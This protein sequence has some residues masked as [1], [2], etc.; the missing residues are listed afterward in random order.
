MRVAITSLFLISLVVVNAAEPIF[1][2]EQNP[3]SKRYSILEED[4]RVAW[5]YLTV[6]GESRPE[7]DALAYSVIEPVERTDW[8]EVKE[9]RSPALS[10]EY[11]S[12]HAVL[13]DRKVSDFSFRWADAGASVALLFRGEVIAFIDSSEKRGFSRALAKPGPLGI[14]L[15]SKKAKKFTS[16]A[17]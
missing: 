10:K 7:K 4:E 13:R 11:A 12:S 5:L 14:P 6:A 17:K 3:V 2:S 16:D 9:G 1:R 8:S 15:D